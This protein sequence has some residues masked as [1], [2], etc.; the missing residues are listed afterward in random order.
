MKPDEARFRA[1]HAAAML[2]VGKPGAQEPPHEY[3][4]RVIAEME[5]RAAE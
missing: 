1:I 3:T 4:L 2:A 5:R